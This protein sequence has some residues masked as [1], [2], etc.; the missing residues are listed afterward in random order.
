MA[1]DV[2]TAS[3]VAIVSKAAKIEASFASLSGTLCSC[4]KE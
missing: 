3:R 2:R 1:I 4:R